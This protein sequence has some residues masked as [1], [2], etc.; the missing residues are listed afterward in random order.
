MVRLELINM[1]LKKMNEKYDNVFSINDIEGTHVKKVS[2]KLFDRVR[3]DFYLYLLLTRYSSGKIDFNNFLNR[4][5]TIDLVKLDVYL[6]NLLVSDMGYGFEI[7]DMSGTD[8]IKSVLEKEEF[9]V[10]SK[11][12]N[13]IGV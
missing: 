6:H 12:I 1:W 10:F 4:I 11:Y 13:S 8:K 9:K 2:V 7:Y 3:S 5:G